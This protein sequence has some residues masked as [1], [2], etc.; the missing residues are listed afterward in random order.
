MIAI[1]ITTEDTPQINQIL[2]NAIEEIRRL[3]PRVIVEYTNHNHELEYEMTKADRDDMKEILAQRERGELK[4]A[5][6]E[7]I[8]RCIEDIISKREKTKFNA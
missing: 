3:S 8:D 5:T 2:Q 6:I 7:E 1:T 4:Y